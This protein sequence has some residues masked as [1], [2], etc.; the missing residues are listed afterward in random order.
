MDDI[1]QI[2]SLTKSYGGEAFIEELDL[3]IKKGSVYG[4]LGPTGS[5]KSTLIK[6]ILGLLKAD[7]GEILIG[8]EKVS[9]ETKKKISY[10]ADINPLYPNFS[11]RDFVKIYGDF[12]ED[13]DEEAALNIL[14][15]LSVP[16]NKENRKLSKGQRKRLRIGLAL[17]RNAEIFL[18]D[19]PME[20]L[21]LLGVDGFLDII[22]RKLDEGASFLIAGHKLRELE[23]ILDYVIFLNKGRIILEEETSKIRRDKQMGMADYYK[24]VYGL[25]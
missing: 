2:K 10:L 1:I 11:A 20:G 4:L 5:G 6:L 9:S 21:D 15:F 8:E 25:L 14:D 17:G 24:E 16:L 19:E 12:Y 3:N 13:F 7:K 22:I 18:L 23:N